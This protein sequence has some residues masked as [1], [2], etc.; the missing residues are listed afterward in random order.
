MSDDAASD[1]GMFKIALGA[2]EKLIRQYDVAWFVFRLQRTDG[3]DADDPCNAELFHGPEIG[4]VIQFAWQDAMAASVAR[5]ENDFA[6]AERASEKFIGWRTK[7]RFDFHPFL[8]GEAFD[9]I[10]SAAA[11]DADFI[12]PHAEIMA[13]QRIASPVFFSAGAKQ[14]I[15]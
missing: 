9:V 12:F 11:D 3:T 1:K 2:V 5:E 13:F 14:I 4:A 8:V 7:R 15:W 6:P 10:K